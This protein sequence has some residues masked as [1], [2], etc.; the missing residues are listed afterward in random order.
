MIAFIGVRISWLIAARNALFAWFASSAA[1]RASCAS[2]EQPGVLDRDRRLLRRARRGSRGRAWVNGSLGSDRQTAITPV[3]RSRAISG[4]TISRS[5][6]VV[7][8]AG[9]RRRVRGSRSDVVD[10]LGARRS[11]ATSPMIPS[12]VDDRVRPDRVGDRA[13]GDDRA[14]R[15]AVR[16]G[17]EDARSSRRRAGAAPRS[18]IRSS[19]RVEVERRRDLPADLG[20]RRHLVGAAMRLPVEPGVLDRVADVRGDRRQQPHVGLAEPALLAACSGR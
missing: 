9:D 17:Q 18:A 12:P 7:V 6:V 4:A 2:R 15:R 5:S 11:A 16:L 10:D 13:E 8:G 20:E 14:E 19:T 3:T 1:S